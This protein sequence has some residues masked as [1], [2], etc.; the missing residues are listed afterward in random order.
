MGPGRTR[1]YQ[2]IAQLGNDESGFRLWHERFINEVTQVHP[3][4]REVIEGMNTRI[5]MEE[6]MSVKSELLALGKEGFTTDKFIEDLFYIL[7]AKCDGEA[8]IK[9][10]TVSSGDGLRAYQE[11]Y[12]WYT[13][14]SGMAMTKRAENIMNP[15]SAKD[16]KI[17][18]NC[19]KDGWLL[20][21]TSPTKVICIICHHLIR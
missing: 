21:T 10:L 12:K 3:A 16:D 4:A 7:L 8:A 15:K 5:D 18:L 2:N 1:G 11:I 6:K 20:S 13:G 17:F 14:T 19:Q 9:V